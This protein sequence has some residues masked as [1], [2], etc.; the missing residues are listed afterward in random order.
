M[1]FLKRLASLFS[2][3][4]GGGGDDHS[5]RVYVRC[6]TCGEP[7]AMR[8]D[9]RN[10]LS[11]EWNSSS[12]AGSDQ[13]D[14]YTCRKEVLGR[15]RCYQKVEVELHFNRQRQ[16]ESQSARG[17][18]L[19]EQEEYQQAVSEWEAKKGGIQQ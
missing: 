16:L 9:L 11:P 18:V 3:G 7:I 8:I 19:L 14:S 2:G 6:N 13:P 15:G 4:G 17:G 10:D 1:G 12:A 5:R